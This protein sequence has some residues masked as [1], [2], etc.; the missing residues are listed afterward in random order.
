MHGIALEEM[1]R[2]CWAMIF[3]LR[4]V[5]IAGLFYSNLNEI[6]SNSVTESRCANH[7][8]DANQE[9]VDVW[10]SFRQTMPMSLSCAQ[11]VQSKANNPVHNRHH[12]LRDK[13]LLPS[14]GAI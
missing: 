9:G 3:R 4:Y 11:P 6:Q 8:R 10:I 2:P 14:F 13:Q 1:E 5:Y 12:V 7:I